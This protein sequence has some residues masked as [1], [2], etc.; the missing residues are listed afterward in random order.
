MLDQQG[1]R[2]NRRN[3]QDIFTP[4]YNHQ[5][6]PGAAQ[7]VHYLL[8][9]PADVTGP[10]ELSARV[11]YRK[12]DFEYLS[13]VHGGDS[14]V[15]KLPVVDLCSDRVVL[16]VAGSGVKVPA[17][18][19]PIAP[20][21]QRWN[22]YGIGCLLEG[23]PDEKKGE[24]R[25]AEEAFKV[26]VAPG[27]PAAAHAHG[28]VNLAR[29]YVAEGRLAEAVKVLNKARKAEPPPPWWTVA[30]FNGLVNV[31]NARN[32]KDFDRAIA[33]F[34]RILD[35]D[36][37]PHHR[38]FDFTRDYVV[39]NKLGQTLFKRSQFELSPGRRDAFL[40][41][42][43]ARYERT[44]ELDPEDLD[45]HY[46]LTQCY[47]TLGL[48]L[49]V[50]LPG[51]QEST[52]TEALQALADK[53]LDAGAAKEGRREAAARLGRAVTE[54]GRERTTAKNPKR[55]RFDALVARVRPFFEKE[56]DADLRA[57]AAAVLGHLHREL[58]AIY[59]PDELATGRATRLYRQKHPAANHAAEAIVIY[60]TNVK[61]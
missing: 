20:A 8:Q 44:L 50:A 47:R 5:I 14:K 59:R 3:P 34:E 28:Y 10:I 15:P 32:A 49:K 56:R 29:V 33:D 26:L 42:A 2:I 31:E 1:R 21:W 24:L 25:Q 37:Q 12:F 27:A 39:I 11:R 22:D 43:I 53:L 40:L 41:R 61:K 58:H 16:P 9:V 52:R 4:L 36:N 48:G 45:A 17:Q 35:P 55:P 23:G 19:S 13:L 57:A 54:L 18:Q 38:K 60:P 6:P 51:G 30:W 46:G 7:V